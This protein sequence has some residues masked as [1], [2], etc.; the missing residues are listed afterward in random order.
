MK[1]TTLDIMQAIEAGYP[2]TVIINGE[3][4]DI[5]TETINKEFLAGILFAADLIEDNRSRR[6]TSFNWIEGRKAKT[7]KTAFKMNDTRNNEAK[8][9][10]DFLRY[11]AADPD[12]VNNALKNKRDF[13]R[14]E[15]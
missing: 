3:N 8:Y 12:S 1:T 10:S 5:D 14:L 13:W 6:N 15:K 9:L 2:V 4:Y 7:T 11:I